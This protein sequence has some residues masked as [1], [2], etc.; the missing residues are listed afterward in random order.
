MAYEPT[1]HEIEV[2]RMLNG[3]REGEWGAWVGACLEF[4]EDAGLCTRGPN[5][6]ITDKGRE[7]LKQWNHERPV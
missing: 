1:S 6:Q 5:Y 2:L 3:E 7:A 4:L